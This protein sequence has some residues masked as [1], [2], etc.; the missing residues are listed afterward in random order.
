MWLDYSAP[1]AGVDARAIDEKGKKGLNTTNEFPSPDRPWTLKEAQRNCFSFAQILAR[2]GGDTLNDVVSANTN[3]PSNTQ[4]FNIEFFY[5]EFAE[6]VARGEGE[7][8]WFGPHTFVMFIR[9]NAGSKEML[10]R[11]VHAPRKPAE[12]FLPYLSNAINQLQDIRAHELNPSIPNSGGE[13]FDETFNGIKHPLERAFKENGEN[14]FH[15]FFENRGKDGLWAVD[16]DGK[17]LMRMSSL[18]ADDDHAKMLEFIENFF[19]EFDLM[20]RMV[21]QCDFSPSAACCAKSSS[22]QQKLSELTID[23]IMIPKSDI[24]L[25][26]AQETFISNRNISSFGAPNGE[27]YNREDIC[28][29]CHEKKDECSCKNKEQNS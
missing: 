1:N 2:R 11:F 19:T 28:A 17:D 13:Y 8:K 5:E 14:H 22:A 24:W 9:T 27:K 16:A 20:N 3:F 26:E 23:E 25:E 6:R 4:D 29:E 15:Y 21:I 10:Q 12:K 7:I 18:A